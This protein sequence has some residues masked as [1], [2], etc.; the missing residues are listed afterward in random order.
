MSPGSASDCNLLTAGVV[1][2]VGVT[3]LTAGV[4]VV[5]VVTLLRPNQSSV[6][7]KE[8]ATAVGE[9]THCCICCVQWNAC[10]VY[11]WCVWYVVF[12][13]VYTCGQHG[14]MGTWMNTTDSFVLSRWAALGDLCK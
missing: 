8:A 11:V 4:G 13:C 2:G 10:T 12:M 5:V 6:T 14:Y 3:L 7:D 1:V 9:R